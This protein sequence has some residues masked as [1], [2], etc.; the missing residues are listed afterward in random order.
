VPLKGTEGYWEGSLAEFLVFDGILK[1]S[2]RKSV[3]N[4]LRR[5]WL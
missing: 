1:D 3:E 2:E 5:K 4:W